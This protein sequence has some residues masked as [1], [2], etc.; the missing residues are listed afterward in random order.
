M[1]TILLGFQKHKPLPMKILLLE[2]VLNYCNKKDYYQC[3]T[4]FKRMTLNLDLFVSTL[5]DFAML[6]REFY[7]NCGI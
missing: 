2:R 6:Q 5:P 7:V 3:R 4:V 1:K